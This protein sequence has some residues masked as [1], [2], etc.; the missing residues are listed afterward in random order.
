MVLQRIYIDGFRHAES[1][2]GICF[3]LAP[4]Y[5]CFFLGTLGSDEA[6]FPRKN[7]PR[8]QN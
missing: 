8:R 3:Q 6:E 1:E 4:L 5:Q 2:C 7:C